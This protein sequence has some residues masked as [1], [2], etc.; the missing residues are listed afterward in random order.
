MK[1]LN[2][3]IL[4]S[5]IAITAFSQSRQELKEQAKNQYKPYQYF[6]DPQVC[7]GCHW[8]KFERWN[9]SQHS[10]AFTGDFFQKQFYDLVIASE[11]FAPE[12]ANVK[13][14]CIGCHAPS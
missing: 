8:E 9:S 10:K 6:E 5:F 4:L 1:S 13:E 14:G 7:A 11:S 2:I 12:V 3:Y